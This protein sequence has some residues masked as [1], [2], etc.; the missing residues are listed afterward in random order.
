MRSRHCSFQ[1]ASLPMW[2]LKSKQTLFAF[3]I[4]YIYVHVHVPY[5]YAIVHVDACSLNNRNLIHYAIFNAVILDIFCPLLKKKI[6][7]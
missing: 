7:T 2:S 5:Y 4:M 6:C 3:A 1:N